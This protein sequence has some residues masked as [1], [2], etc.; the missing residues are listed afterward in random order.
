LRAGDL[1]LRRGVDTF[2]DPQMCFPVIARKF[3]VQLKIFP[4]PILR[5]FVTNLLN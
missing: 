2:P 3:P 1:N 4:V 5:E